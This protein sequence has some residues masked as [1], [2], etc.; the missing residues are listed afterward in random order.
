M[1]PRASRIRCKRPLSNSS[2]PDSCPKTTPTSPRSC[3]TLP[4]RSSRVAST[5]PSGSTSPSCI[6]PARCASS[7]SSVS[8]RC[9]SPPLLDEDAVLHDC[10]GGRDRLQ[11]V[12]AAARRQRHPLHRGRGRCTGRACCLH[13]WRTKSKVLAQIRSPAYLPSDS[14]PLTDA[15]GD[16]E[17]EFGAQS[18]KSALDGMSLSC[19][20]KT[21]SSSPS[22]A[23]APW[24]HDYPAA[25]TTAIA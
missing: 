22:R 8:S 24:H 21:S 20:S 3:T 25:T 9:A 6:L 1:R 14:A 23:L 12:G 16:L 2:P 13:V 5:G 4:S 17:C 19:H 18:S 10:T 11:L 15:S 7:T